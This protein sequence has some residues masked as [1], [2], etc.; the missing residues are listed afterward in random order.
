MESRAVHGAQ[1]KDK[2][3][4]A[5]TEIQDIVKRRKPFFTIRV[6]EHWHRLP[7]EVVETPPLKIFKDQ[8]D[9]V[10]GTLLQ[11]ILL[12]RRD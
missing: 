3:P 11:L 8:L 4:Q 9:V 12:E 5:W 2:R 1:W 6:I 7:R 10:L